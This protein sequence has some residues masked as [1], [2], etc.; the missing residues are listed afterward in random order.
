MRD[1]SKEIVFFFKF[2]TQLFKYYLAP[3]RDRVRSVSLA[4]VIKPNQLLKVKIKNIAHVWIDFFTD[5]RRTRFLLRLQPAAA[6]RRFTRTTTRRLYTYP[7]IRFVI[8]IERIWRERY[9]N[10]PSSGLG[11]RSALSSRPAACFYFD[12]SINKLNFKSIKWLYVRWRWRWWDCRC[13]Q[14]CFSVLYLWN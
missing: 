9:I 7:I 5:A 1:Y 6:T 8:F 4:D 13:R 12:H 3:T 14:S 11:R 10:V 2:E